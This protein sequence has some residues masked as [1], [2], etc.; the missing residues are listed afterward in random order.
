[1]VSKQSNTVTV[2]LQRC[3]ISEAAETRDYGHTQTHFLSLSLSLILSDTLSP[4]FCIVTALLMYNKL[5]TVYFM[6][7]VVCMLIECDDDECLTEVMIWNVCV[8][9]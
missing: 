6:L 2:M 1:V 9:E 3:R 8:C 7:L 4:I 5:T